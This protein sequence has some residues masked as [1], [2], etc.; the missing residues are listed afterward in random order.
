[1]ISIEAIDPRTIRIIFVVPP[2]YVGLHGQV[3]LRYTSSQENDSANWESQVFAPPDDLIATSQL[4][5]ELPNLEP[6]TEY[7]VK[8]SLKL[9]D[10][11]SKPSS[12]V[13]HVKTPGYSRPTEVIKPQVQT[14]TPRILEE[15]EDPD[16]QSAEVNSTWIKFTWRKLLDDELELIDGIQLRYKE[17]DGMVYAAT[18]LIH[19]TLTS[20]MIEGLKPQTDYEVGL[21]FIPFPGHGDEIRGGDMLRIQTAQLTNPYE[22]DVMVNVTKIKQTSVEVS[23]SGVPYPED[24]YVNIYRVIYQSDSGKEDSSVFKVAKR[25]SNTGTLIAD[26][27][28]GTRY[29]LWIEM[30]LTNGGIKKSNVVDVQTKPGNGP[31]LGKTG[32]LLTAGAGGESAEYYGPFVVAAC[33]AAL[34]IATTLVLLLIFTR[35]RV[36]SAAITPPRKSEASYDNPSYKVEIQ[37]ETM[38]KPIEMSQTNGVSNG[39][40]N[41]NSRM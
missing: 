13:Y 4:E 31:V 35:R 26:L 19:R 21:F 23:W 10:W 1:V 11:N 25:D 14:T 12:R 15:I 24:K 8:I 30:Y 9:F 36:Q 28:P 29:R 20:Y 3:E 2:V 17:W 27:K 6:D 33:I 37:Q 22:F 39:D 16:L 18:P 38:S 5:F 32:K 34:A 41:G 7:K 40:S